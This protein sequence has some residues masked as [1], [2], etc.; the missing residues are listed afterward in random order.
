MAAVDEKIS[1]VRA[2]LA[3]AEAKKNAS[4]A[5]AVSTR[6]Q[7]MLAERA[8]TE[9]E[10]RARLGMAEVRS[11]GAS[12]NHSQL[13]GPAEMA[14]GA[15]CEL[16]IVTFTSS[17]EPLYRGGERAIVALAA[18]PGK[19]VTALRDLGDGSYAL[20]VSASVAGEYTITATIRGKQL[21][22]SPHTL[23][24]RMPEG[25]RLDLA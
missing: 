7:M 25:M 22:G 12:A 6:L 21:Q 23:L 15:T 4:R 13:S 16:K 11:D 10:T 17:R 14:S 18:G 20:E 1:I 19:A 24:V 5:E 2:D 8:I 3:A 9:A